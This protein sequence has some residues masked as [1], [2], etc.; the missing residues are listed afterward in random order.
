VIL[1]P[2]EVPQIATK[3]VRLRGAEQ[4]RLQRIGAYM[5][6]KHDPP[7]APKGVNSEYRWIMKKSRRNFLPL[8]VSVV[9]QNLHVDG[10]KPGGATAVETVSSAAPEPAWSAYEANRMISRQH[11]VHRSVIEYGAA[12]VLV[13]PGELATNEEL[14]GSSVP[15][16][17]PVSPRRMTPFYADDVDDEWP[18]IAIEVRTVNNAAEPLK[19]QLMVSLYDEQARYTML[20]QPGITVPD[21]RLDLTIAAS[22]D[23]NLGGQLPI[24]YHNLNV[25]PVVR[26]LYEID[27]DGDR[28][29]QGE[30]EPIMALQDQINFDTFNCMMAEQYQAFRQRW[31]TG[32]A[33]VDAE[34]R[35]TAPFRPG[36]DRVWAAED[37]TTK[38][39]EFG[40]AQLQ[41]YLEAREAAIRH[42]STITQVPPYHLLGQIANLSAEALAAARD[43]LDRKIAELQ[44][45]LTDPW[46]NVFRLTALAASD[47]SGWDDTNGQVVWRDTSARAFAAT[48]DGLGKA[49]TMLEIPVEELWKR[50]PGA[51]A[52]DVNSWLRAKQQEEAEAQADAAVAEAMQFQKA[53]VNLAPVQTEIAA[54]TPGGQGQPQASQPGQPAKAALPAARPAPPRPRPGGRAP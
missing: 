28:D 22:E 12:Y 13:L 32:M 30:V 42:M 33:P 23:P 31:V 2:D 9:S 50:V 54:G 27:L 35:E 39:G 21:D 6:G 26:F 48:I 43:G 51:T 45:N 3:L 15:V 38:F 47:K 4:R 44:S 49:A 19:Q 24:A 20:S 25:C 7:Y 52:D 14:P 40:E 41:Q 34:G 46:R 1:D 37:P 16:I 18:Q 53:G 10:Y 11:G 29:C 5:E 36:V 17:R 8:V